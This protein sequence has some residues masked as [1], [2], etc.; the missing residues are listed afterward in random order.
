[1]TEQQATEPDG[2]RTLSM[3]EASADKEGKNCFTSAAKNNNTSLS[4][5]ST[6]INRQARH[7]STYKFSNDNT[8]SEITPKII[9]LCNIGS[10]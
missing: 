10:K 7:E 1:M 4:F 6:Y 3:V 9:K 8:L 2:R 5:F